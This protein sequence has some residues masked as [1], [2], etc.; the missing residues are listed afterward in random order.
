MARLDTTMHPPPVRIGLAQARTQ[1]GQMLH[2]TQRL[3]L[4]AGDYGQREAR[5]SSVPI[6]LRIQRNAGPSSA[7]ATGAVKPLGHTRRKRG[8]PPI[9]LP[10]ES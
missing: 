1:Q 9:T 7:I 5:F 3:A 8:Y 10:D 4:A 2:D 6:R